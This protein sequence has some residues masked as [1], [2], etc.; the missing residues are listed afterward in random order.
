V[1]PPPDGFG[2]LLTDLSTVSVENVFR[3]VVVCCANSFSEKNPL[4][5]IGG[6]D[7]PVVAVGGDLNGTFFLILVMSPFH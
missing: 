5:G 3:Q 2:K 6:F 1:P 4:V 7:V